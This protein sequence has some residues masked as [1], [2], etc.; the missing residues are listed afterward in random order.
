MKT[1]FQAQHLSLATASVA[2]VA[3]GNVTPT[4]AAALYASAE[5]PFQ[6]AHI[7]SRGQIV[8][9]QFCGRLAILPI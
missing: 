2:L 4:E 9:E 1:L 5:L 7:T 3:L 6:P 8:G